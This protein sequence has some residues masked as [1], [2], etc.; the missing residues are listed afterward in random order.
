[1]SQEK[2]KF[3]EGRRNPRTWRE[4]ESAVNRSRFSQ[5]PLSGRS[6][7]NFALRL[8]PRST[9]DN[10]ARV[11]FIGSPRDSIKST[12]LYIDF[13]KDRFTPPPE[14]YP[15]DYGPTRAALRLVD[16]VESGS[17]NMSKEETLQRERKRM[18]MIGITSYD[19]HTESGRFV[20][21]TNGKLYT[22][23]D[24]FSKEVDIFIPT[25]F[26]FNMHIKLFAFTF[27]LLKY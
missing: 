15:Q 8:K 25:Y 20:F 26:I 6:I 10:G 22:F 4:I 11:Y 24:D 2:E 23:I 12:L 14:P 21:P 9:E 5:V 1:M 27:T 19:V 16:H 3:S 17:F 13:S 18:A 7:Q